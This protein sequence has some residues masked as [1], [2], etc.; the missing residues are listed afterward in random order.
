MKKNKTQKKTDA[1]VMNAM[2]GEMGGFEYFVLTNWKKLLA[3][4]GAVCVVVVIALIVAAVQKSAAQKAANAL[5]SASDEAALVQVLKEYGS[6]KSAAVARMRLANIYINGGKYDK[7]MEQFELVEKSNPAPEMVSRIRLGQAYLLELSGKSAEAAGRLAAL[8]LDM[9]MSMGMR[10]EAGCGAGRIYL[11]L[12]DKARAAEILKAVVAMKNQ[13]GPGNME[14][15]S[16]AQFL[17][18]NAGK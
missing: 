18:L 11:A 16:M 5:N 10:A 4:L 12:G 7:A 9:G 2:F 17:L 13:V 6:N 1:A 15:C 14:W 3:G 8:S